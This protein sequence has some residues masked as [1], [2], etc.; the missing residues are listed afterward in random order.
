MTSTLYRTAKHCASIAQWSGMC[1]ALGL[2]VMSS[3][4]A[5]PPGRGVN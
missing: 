5:A 4:F 3:N 2:P 1:G